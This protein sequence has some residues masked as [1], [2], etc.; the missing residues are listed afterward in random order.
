[1]TRDVNEKQSIILVLY[2]DDI[3]ILCE[4]EREI[5][6]VIESCRNKYKE[7]TS[8]IGNYFCYLG[9]HIVSRDGKAHISMEG[10]I[11]ELL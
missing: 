6:N 11:N 8:S 9:M 4:D 10:Y 2:V 1:M 7:I 3:L 5:I